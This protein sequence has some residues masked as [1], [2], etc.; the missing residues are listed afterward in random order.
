MATVRWRDVD[1]PE[2]T[3]AFDTAEPVFA[4]HYL[5]FYFSAATAPGHAT[6]VTT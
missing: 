3:G 2:Q 1:I 6:A 5:P 4:S